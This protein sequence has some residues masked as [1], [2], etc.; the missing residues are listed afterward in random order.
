MQAYVFIDAENHFIRSAEAAARVIGSARAAEALGR[1]ENL[2]LPGIGGF[3]HSI[4]GRRFGW[5]A[6]LQ[7]FW[8]CELLSRC[9]LLATLAVERIARAIYFC[10][11]A[12]DDDAVHRVRERL[13]SYDF[14]PVVIP[15]PKQLQ[16][17]R[18]TTREHDGLIDKPKGCDIALATRMISDAAADLYD[19]CMLFTSD[20]DFLPVVEAVRRRGKVVWVLGYEAVLAKRS[21]YSYV[22]DRFFDLEKFLRHVWHDKQEGVE[23]ALQSIGELGPFHT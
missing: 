18:R 7:L 6:E 23:A 20:A 14:E 12:G 8:D 2:L 10:S 3:P 5:D 9:G 21:P 16:K 11:C 4:E 1:A 13:R 17:Q 22:P 15:E 19:C